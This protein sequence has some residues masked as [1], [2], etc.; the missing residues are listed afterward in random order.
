MLIKVVTGLGMSGFML[1]SVFMAAR[2]RYRGKT[3]PAEKPEAL[4]TALAPAEALRHIDWK[5]RLAAINALEQQ[6]D[7]SLLPDVIQVLN[8]A[9]PD[10]REAAARVVAEADAAAVDGL[11]SVLATGN[12]D[13]RTLAANLLKH[14]GDERA[15]PALISALHDHSVH[16]RLPAV[17]A[18]GKIGGSGVVE[19]LAL[20]RTNDHEVDVKAAAA[21]ALRRIGT[22]EALAAL[23]S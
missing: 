16:V 18:L 6:P 9:D 20:A 2:L 11:T 5:I 14:S 22:P 23:K 19:A 3:K 13:A 15:V 21:K 8:D 7:E 4:S 17:E 12:L 10:V 1:A